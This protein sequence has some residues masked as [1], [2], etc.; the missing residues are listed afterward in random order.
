MT[1]RPYTRLAYSDAARVV[2]CPDDPARLRPL[3]NLG[4]EIPRAE[5]VDGL[6]F[7]C[8]P[9]GSEWRLAVEQPGPVRVWRVRGNELHPLDGGEALRAVPSQGERTKLEVT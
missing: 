1:T 9:D 6:W 3:Y 4:A 7:G 5:F 8:W 2:H